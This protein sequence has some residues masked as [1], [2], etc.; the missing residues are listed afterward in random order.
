MTV[1]ELIEKLSQYPDD[2]PVI[3]SIDEEGNGFNPIY[4]VEESMWFSSWG[5]E[6]IYPLDKY[7]GFDGYTEEDRAPEGSIRAVVLWP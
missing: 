7:I 3:L 6:Q 1:G 5:E 2:M 4:V